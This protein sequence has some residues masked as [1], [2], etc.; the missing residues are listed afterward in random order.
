MSTTLMAGAA[1]GNL[2]PKGKMGDW[3][4]IALI[5]IVII[6][7]YKMVTG[8]LGIFSSIL[9]SLGLKD[10]EEEKA[11]KEKL[12][13]EN[14][15]SADI[16]SPWSPLFYKSAP[17]G[18]KLKNYDFTVTQAYRIWDSVGAF[19]DNPEQGLAAIKTMPSQAA[20][21][22]LCDIFNQ[23]YKKDLAEWL[24]F[25]YDTDSQK[26]VMAK[27]FDYVNKLPKY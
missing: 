14:A 13:K 23:Q 16:K 3:V 21:S 20:I 24:V 25:K 4:K 7:L 27:I 15:N 18:A 1:A 22:F 11:L 9:E 12:A 17:A 5:I 19:S 8:S 26:A 6:V 10:T 2:L